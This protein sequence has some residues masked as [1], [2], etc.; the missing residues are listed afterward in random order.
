M[1]EA[2]LLSSAILGSL[3]AMRQNEQN[4]PAVVGKQL[5]SGSA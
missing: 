2:T 5:L 3:G 4:A 1:I